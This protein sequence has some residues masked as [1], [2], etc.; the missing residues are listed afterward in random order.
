MIECISNFIFPYKQYI[1]YSM[2]IY[3]KKSSNF[4]AA[5]TKPFH[6][7][8]GHPPHYTELRAPRGSQKI[9]ALL[10]TKWL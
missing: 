5:E 7:Q 6:Q 4:N 3:I 8:T 10:L 1:L 2:Y 9:M